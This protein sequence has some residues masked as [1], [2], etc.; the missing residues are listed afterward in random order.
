MLIKNTIYF[1]REIFSNSYALRTLVIRDFQSRYLASYIG[2]PWAFIQPSAYILVV[3]FAFSVGLRT[4]NTSAG[5]PFAAWL[6]VAM[7]PW[8]FI[9]Q[10]MQVSS[11]SLAEYSYLIKKTKINAAVIPLIK[12]LSGLMV[13]IVLIV[14]IMLI[15]IFNYKIYPSI[16]WIQIFYYMFATI[17]VLTGIS[18]F[19]AAIDVFMSDMG[20]LVTVLSTML[21][22]ATPI[23]WPYAMLEGNLKYI[24]LLNPFFYITEG[25]RYTF[26]QEKWF[27]Q[28]AEMNIFFWSVTFVVFIAGALTFRKLKPEF[29]DVL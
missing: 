9:S 15:L 16:Y 25:Y 24:A 26:L 13:H 20:H 23:I 6:M 22:W 4:G 19:V 3:W 28:F 8:L 2:L 27:F 10:T 17:V 21:F 29:G 14:L 18:W 11:K 5:T 12:V 1:V 7:I